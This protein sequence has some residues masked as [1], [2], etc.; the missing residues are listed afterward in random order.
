MNVESQG[1]DL[2][3]IRNKLLKMQLFVRDIVVDIEFAIHNE[4]RQ[5]QILEQLQEF[6]DKMQTEIDGVQDQLL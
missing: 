5:D 6:A 2:T 3:L 1:Y 4:D